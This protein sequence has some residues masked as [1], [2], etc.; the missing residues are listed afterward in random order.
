MP[1]FLRY[2]AVG[3]A[4][5]GLEYA[6]FLA[7]HHGLAWSLLAANTVAFSLGLL[8][9]FLINKFWVFHGRQ[10]Y[11]TRYQ[12]VAYCALALFNYSVGTGLLIYL[13]SS[14]HVGAWL[15][16]I[17]SMAAIVVWNFAIY[18]KVIYR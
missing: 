16:K 11:Q 5:A 12:F 3:L 7:L 1:Q 17:L 9:S 15:A 18:K 4:C 2:L 8:S 6:S 14:L 13:A 10:Q